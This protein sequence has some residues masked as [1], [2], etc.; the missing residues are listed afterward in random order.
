VKSRSLLVA[1]IS[2]L[3]LSL[4]LAGAALGATPE[5][6]VLEVGDPR[7]EGEGPGLGVLSVSPLIVALAVLGLGLV[8]AAS[9][10]VATRLMRHHR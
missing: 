2:L 8:A 5:P 3:L 7:S 9:T 10:L 6:S 4:F 1:S